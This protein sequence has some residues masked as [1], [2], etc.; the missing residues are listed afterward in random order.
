[1]LAPK[2]SRSGKYV[3]KVIRMRFR[4][5]LGVQFAVANAEMKVMGSQLVG[6]MPEEAMMLANKESNQKFWSPNTNCPAYFS[7]NYGQNGVAIS[8]GMIGYR[9]NNRSPRREQILDEV[10]YGPRNVNEC[11]C[12]LRLY[13]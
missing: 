8:F 5:I 10:P 4:L 6:K 9:V 1:M 13:L 11:C 12:N 3:E 2:T 7:A